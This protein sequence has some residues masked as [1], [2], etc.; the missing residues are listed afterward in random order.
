MTTFMDIFHIIYNALNTLVT[1]LIAFIPNLIIAALIWWIGTFLLDIAVKLIVK[2][3]VKGIAM[4]DKAIDFLAKLVL[5]TGRVLLILT[6]LDYLGIAR[7]IIAALLNAVSLA[8]AITLGLAFGKAC[9]QDAQRLVG[10]IR[11]MIQK[12]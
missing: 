8:I 5:Y 3:K 11:T 10:Y 12:S 1:E 7:T 9:E 2:L 6:I 4:E